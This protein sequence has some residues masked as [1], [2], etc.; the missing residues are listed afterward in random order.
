MSSSGRKLGYSTRSDLKEWANR[1]TQASN[2]LPRLIRRLVLETSPGVSFLD[3]PAGDGVMTGGWDGGCRAST[4]T[5][6]VPEGLSLWELS[7]DK[8]PGVKAD[9]D[10]GK[11]D[12]TPDGTACSDAT[13]VEAIVRPWTKRQT[14]ATAKAADGKWRDVKAL[15]LDDLDEWLE[16]APVT[17]AWFSEL[18]GLTPFGLQSPERWWKVWANLTEP[19]LT[20]EMLLAGRE[21]A[22]E[23]LEA[24]LG[25]PGGVFTI[26]HPNADEVS[27]FIAAFVHQQDESQLP[28][29]L[30]RTAFVDDPETFRRLLAEQSRPLLLVPAWPNMAR[31]VPPDS[32]HHVVVPT[33]VDADIE[34][35]LV[36]PAAVTTALKNLGVDRDK[37]QEHGQFARRSLTAFRRRLAKSKALMIP[38]WA[39]GP[40]RTARAVVLMHSWSDSNEHDRETAAKIAG[41]GYDEFRERLLPLRDPA[42]PLLQLFASGW[43]LVSP[44]DAWRLLQ[45]HLTPDDLQRLADAAAEV[46]GEDD[47]A[48]DYPEDQR[49]RASLEGHTRKHSF[50]LR[51]GLA[52][53][54]ALL[55]TV[56]SEID[57]PKGASGVAWATHTVRQLLKP[58]VEDATGRRWIS[59]VDQ[60]GPLIEAAPNVMLDALEESCA[61]D[62]P[63]LRHIFRDGDDQLLGSSSPHTQLLWALERAAWS[64]EHFAAAVAVLALLDGLDPGGT[65][66]NRPFQSLADIFCP[67]NP[68]TTV[69]VAGRLAALDRLCRHDPDLHWRLLVAQLPDRGGWLTPNAHPEYRSWRPTGDR[70]VTAVEYNELIDALM[71]RCLTAVGNDLERWNELL[72]R[73]G[74]LPPAGRAAVRSALLLLA[75]EDPAMGSSDREALWNVVQDLV[76]KH[77]EYSESQWALPADEVG[78]LAEVADALDPDDPIAVVRRLFVGASPFLANVDRRDDYEAHRGA[79]QEARASAIRDLT[80]TGGLAA[81]RDLAGRDGIQRGSVGMALSRAYGEDFLP[82]MVEDL[83]SRPSADC[84]LALD[85]IFQMYLDGGWRWLCEFIE[86]QVGDLTS[87]ML[88]VLLAMVNEYPDAAEKAEDLGSEVA[89]TFWRR[90]GTYGLYGHD[91]EVALA[92]VP[93]LLGVGRAAAALDVINIHSRRD[94]E[95][96]PQLAVQAADSLETLAQSDSDPDAGALQHYVFEEIFK[97]LQEQAEAVGPDRVATLEWQ[98]LTVLGFDPDARILHQKMSTDPSFFLEVLTAIYPGNTRAEDVT[99]AEERRRVGE[100]AYRVLASWS[101]CPGTAREDQS[102]D[103]D[104]LREWLETSV[105]LANAAGIGDVARQRIGKVLIYAASD[106]G[107]IP[108]AEIRDMLEELTDKQIETGVYLGIVNSRG[109]TTRSPGDGGQQERNLVDK[110]QDQSASCRERWPRTARVLRDVAQS[111]ESDA[112]RQDR[113]AEA[114]R[115]GDY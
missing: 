97:L 67:W 96:S 71:E 32:I 106:D 101:L 56:G 103:P 45:K 5:A 21:E 66:T 3:F 28:R 9:K 35:D 100:L 89:D 54:L 112:R 59:L 86:S 87:E 63:P 53:S 91:V 52:R 81:V 83:R 34:L 110:Y 4:A 84:D 108:S 95:S 73:L 88:G 43:S 6:W 50:V 64:E 114:F 48:L 15:G 74:Y 38:P 17:H 47:P 18:L 40:D 104:A 75:S 70:D 22:A 61:G 36:D 2:E 37:A 92:V 111:Y 58:A 7:V 65:W 27:A 13:Y 49:W 78:A 57:G 98:F 51:R 31:E 8:S 20:A 46:L 29:H 41:L 109:V 113:N 68:Q 55:A 94:N 19:G 16:A 44:I 77:Q 23:K 60:I 42:D 30:G 80:D 79:V 93:R 39:H 85:Y 24:R 90:F 99:P 82:D 1:T 62:N 14:W 12:A 102:L 107:I 11:R 69:G 26:G 115:R 10:Y 76:E 105:A 72:D 25:R 33:T